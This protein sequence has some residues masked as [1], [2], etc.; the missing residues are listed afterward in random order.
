MSIIGSQGL[1]KS[2]SAKILLLP[3]SSLFF[4]LFYIIVFLFLQTDDVALS[5]KYI[6][7]FN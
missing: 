2:Q 1:K 3:L 5:T 6:F 7:A 4:F